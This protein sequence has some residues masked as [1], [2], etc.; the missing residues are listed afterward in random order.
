MGRPKVGVYGLTS[1][2]GDQLTLINCEDELLDIVG[3]IDLQSF[4][5]AQSGNVEGELDVALVEGA[6]TN[7]HDAKR[8]R[9][10]RARSGLLI[11]FGTCAAWGGV[12]ASA[13]DLPREQ[14]KE[15]VYGSEAAK[16]YQVSKALPLDRF[17]AVDFAIS[18]CPIEKSEL[19]T[20]LASLL[21]GDIP[22]LPGYAV[23]TECK[24]QENVCQM[25]DLDQ[26]C[27]GPITR[28]GC[29]ARCP[30]HNRYC[31][32]CRGPVEEAN[33]AS[34]VALLREKGFTS[35]Q[36]KSRLRIFAYPCVELQR[37]VGDEND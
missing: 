37:A 27:L 30:S 7:E 5:M 17:V 8:L 28:A 1:C 4:A 32:G 2:A 35:E 33:F 22:L 20:S 3:A 25:V 13:N 36:V 23:C 34:E 6:V 14:L 12:P 26:I 16:Y 15:V 11:A 31:V 10:I 24:M 18:G 29:H 21:H 9:D 19:I